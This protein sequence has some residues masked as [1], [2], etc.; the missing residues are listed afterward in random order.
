[1][2]NTSNS[3][4]QNERIILGCS[5]IAGMSPTDIASDTN[6]VLIQP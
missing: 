2:T 6:W 1:M 4:S 3:I 5:A